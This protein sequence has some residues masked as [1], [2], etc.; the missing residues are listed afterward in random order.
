MRPRK[1]GYITQAELAALAGVSRSGI[2]RF[3][4]EKGLAGGSGRN[5]NIRED[6]A[7]GLVREFRD[8]KKKQ[9]KRTELKKGWLS[10]NFL[11]VRAG[12]SASTMS[13]FLHSAG[14]RGYMPVPEDKADE[15]LAEF[16]EWKRGRKAT[17]ER[18]ETLVRRS[19]RKVRGKAAAEKP[20]DWRVSIRGCNGW[21]VVRTGTRDEMEPWADLLLR[22]GIEARASQN[23]AGG[24]HE[25]EE[26]VEHQK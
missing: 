12:V 9:G 24:Q 13:R 16:G 1:R 8:W 10:A 18:P 2:R 19:S 4:E 7:K 14:Y 22:N 23:S 21:L 25:S 5:Q 6:M 11:A 17:R 3:L 20:C 26:S 15:V